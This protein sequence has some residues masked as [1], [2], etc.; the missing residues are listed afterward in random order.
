M[1]KESNVVCGE[2]P[3]KPVVW[4]VMLKALPPEGD[5]QQTAAYA[6]SQTAFG[7][8]TKASPKL[9]NPPFSDVLCMISD[10][11]VSVVESPVEKMKKGKKKR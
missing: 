9:G 1:S 3:S 2:V 6:V 8:F 5:L 7:A 10:L 4:K 11:P